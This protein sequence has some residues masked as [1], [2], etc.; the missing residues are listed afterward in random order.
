MQLFQ[1]SP[2]ILYEKEAFEKRNLDFTSGEEIDAE[3][4]HISMSVE[5][6]AMIEKC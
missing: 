2:Y 1:I 5:V 6:E 4:C 3:K